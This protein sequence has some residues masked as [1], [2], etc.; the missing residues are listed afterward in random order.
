MTLR[1][2][3]E[4]VPFG[5][6]EQKYTV[7]TLNIHNTGRG[8]LGMYEYYGDYIP[9]GPTSEQ[10]I[11]FSGIQHCRQEGFKVLTEKVLNHIVKD[12]LMDS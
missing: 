8:S 5:N 9:V 12:P 6:E 1:V 2:T 4:I 11:S 7:G 10:P 3:F